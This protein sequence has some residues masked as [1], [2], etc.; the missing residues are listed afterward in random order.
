DILV[1][2]DRMS[3]A[4]SLEARAP[5]LDYKMVEF[6]FSLPSHFKVRGPVTKW[7]FK[8]AME[9]ILPDEIIYRRKEGF[10]IPIKSWLRS[11]LKELMMEY[12]SEKRVKESGFFN[13]DY[14]KR[15]IEEHLSGRRDHVH[16]LWALINF[17][18]WRERFF[19]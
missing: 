16:R 17:N 13:Y 9:G 11:E 7:F 18:L 10:S 4:A 6:A 15:M 3:M 2:V 1:K 14:I 12:L 8:K 5:L 19:I